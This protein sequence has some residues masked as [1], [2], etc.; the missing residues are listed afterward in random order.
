MQVNK[1]VTLRVSTTWLQLKIMKS[2]KETDNSVD[3]VRSTPDKKFEDDEE[4]YGQIGE[5]YDNYEKQLGG[6][7]E[8]E[9]HFLTCLLPTLVVQSFL[10]R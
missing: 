7:R 1:S 10:P 8:R 4:I 3:Y 9:K 6:Y 2:A 5:D